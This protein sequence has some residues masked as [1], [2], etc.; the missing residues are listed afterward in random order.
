MVLSLAFSGP[1]SSNPSDVVCLRDQ[2]CIVP[3]VF[4]FLRSPNLRNLEDYHLIEVSE[5]TYLY[6]IQL[7]CG[8]R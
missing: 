6:M 3:R 1:H 8:K 5:C 4:H 7:W 2:K